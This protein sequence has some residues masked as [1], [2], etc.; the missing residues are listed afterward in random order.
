[1]PVLVS[2][3]SP[4]MSPPRLAVTPKSGAIVPPPASSVTYR[5]ELSVAVTASVPAVV[6]SPRVSSPV[7]APSAWSSAMKSVLSSTTLVPPE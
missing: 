3:P 4:V 5:V 2:P 6:S 7:L 1:M